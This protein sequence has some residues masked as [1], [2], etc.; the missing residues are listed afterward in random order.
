MPKKSNPAVDKRARRMNLKETLDIIENQIRSEKD[1]IS[2][3]DYLREEALG[4]LRKA[5]LA[6]Q[7]RLAL[8]EGAEKRLAEYEKQLTGVTLDI[9][10]MDHAKDLEKM[11][12]MRQKLKAEGLVK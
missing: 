2:R 9:K 1:L 5:E 8:L 3:R 10:K 12:E 11:E 6:C 7:T 4:Q